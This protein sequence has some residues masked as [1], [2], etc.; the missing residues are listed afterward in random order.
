MRSPVLLGHGHYPPARSDFSVRPCT[1]VT[2][3][4]DNALADCK[5][6]GW[7]LDSEMANFATV[8]RRVHLV[9]ADRALN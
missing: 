5:G 1:I 2:S 9:L 7:V 8:T 4:F 6:V 3:Y